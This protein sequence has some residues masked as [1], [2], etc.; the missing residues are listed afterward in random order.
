MAKKRKTATKTAAPSKA[1]KSHKFTHDDHVTALVI[2]WR[3]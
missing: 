1:V 2:A 3:S